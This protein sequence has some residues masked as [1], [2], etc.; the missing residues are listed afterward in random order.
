MV[1]IDEHPICD[2][3]PIISSA[4]RADP[5]NINIVEVDPTIGEIRAIKEMALAVGGSRVT[6]KQKKQVKTP[7][8][9]EL[10]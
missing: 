4:T 8:G 6:S 2:P 3:I 5:T 9:S 7:A 10:R 1:V